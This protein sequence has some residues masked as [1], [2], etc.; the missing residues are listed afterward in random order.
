[1]LAGSVT[2]DAARRVPPEMAVAVK[3]RMAGLTGRYHCGGG[4]W[5]FTAYMADLYRPG[6]HEVALYDIERIRGGATF[7]P[8]AD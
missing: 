2:N 8:L 5:E 7:H 3:G 6:A 4:S 1:V